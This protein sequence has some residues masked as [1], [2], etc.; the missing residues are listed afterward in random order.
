MK[1]SRILRSAPTLPAALVIALFAQNAFADGVGS[2]RVASGLSRPVYVASPP[3]DTERLFVVEQHV[4]RIRILKLDSGELNATPFLSVTGLATGNEQGLLGLAFDPDYWQNGYFYVNLNVANGTTEI[5]RYQTSSDNPDV[6]DPASLTRV[7][8]YSQPFSNHNGGWLDFGP[9]GYLYIA[10]GDGGS[11]NDPGNRAQQIVNQKLGKLLRI[12]VSGDDF[13]GDDRR[14]Y[15][16]PPSN[17]FVGIEGDDEIWAYGLRNPWRCSFDRLTGELYIADVGQGQREEISIQP[18]DSP[19]GENYGWRMMEGFRCHRPNEAIACIHPSLTPPVHDYMHSGA[20]DGGVSVTGG[21]VYRGPI[22]SLQGRYFFAD[23]GSSQVW[24]FVWNGNEIT[25]FENN[26]VGLEP[27]VGRIAGITSF[28]EDELGNLYITTLNGGLYKIVCQTAF[29]GDFNGD[30]EINVDDFAL[31][32]DAWMSDANDSDWDGRFDISEP[33]D[34]RVDKQDMT[35]LIEHSLAD[36]LMLNYWRLNETEGSI[37]FDSTLNEQHATV[38][39]DAVWQPALGRDGALELNGIDS[40]LSTGIQVQPVQGSLTIS[41]WIQGGQPGQTILASNQSPIVWLGAHAAD[42]SLWTALKGSGR[43][44]KS[45]NSGVIVT[46]GQWHQVGLTYD[47]DKG[48]RSLF[49]DGALVASDVIPQGPPNEV[50]GD[51]LFGAGPN[52]VPGEFWS[53]LIDD[54]QVFDRIASPE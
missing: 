6:A 45:M 14:N 41:L 15:A 17:P 39:G 40:Y 54:I 1:M 29:S 35:V 30:C 33:A 38:H 7:L 52:L 8:T 18:A 12:D 11:A 22:A 37:A 34:G 9:D 53:G 5:R 10:S 28:G 16:I 47:V 50:T 46:D 2:E 19:G 49:V 3:G 32:A 36:P 25:A 13:P 51:W 24:S 23:F 43:A 48:I 27:D 42:G 20:P 26:T 44:A 4:G 21:Y 31:L